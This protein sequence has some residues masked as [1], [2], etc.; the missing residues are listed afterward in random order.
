MKK[1]SKTVKKA[2]VDLKG[3]AFLL[4]WSWGHDI[5]SEVL[6]LVVG[7][8]KSVVK[9]TC[10]CFFVFHIM[11]KECFSH[12]RVSQTVLDERL[13]RTKLEFQVKLH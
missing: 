1:S 10:M 13:N 7:P 4:Y 9:L 5:R 8:E 11:S 3:G 2:T 6:L 12:S